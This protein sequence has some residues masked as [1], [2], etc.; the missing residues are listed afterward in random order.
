MS[1][2]RLASQATTLTM[3]T[4]NPVA[5]SPP[6]AAVSSSPREIPANRD[7]ISAPVNTKV[8]VTSSGGMAASYSPPSL[9]AKDAAIAPSTKPAGN[10]SRMNTSPTA[11]QPAARASNWPISR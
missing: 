4:V 2:I 1:T 7:P 8:S 11:V 10:L 9:P 3:A 6:L 5:T